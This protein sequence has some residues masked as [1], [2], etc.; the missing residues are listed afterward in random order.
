MCTLTI[1][2]KALRGYPIVALHNRYVKVGAVELTPR[3]IEASRR[4]YY[5]VDVASGGTWIG[6]NEDGLLV[7]VTNQDSHRIEEPGR[8]RGLLALDLLGMYSD[9]AEAKEHL[10]EPG[11]RGDYRWGNFVAMDGGSAWHVV[12]DRETECREIGE[13]AYAVSNLTPTAGMDRTE[14]VEELLGNAERRRSRALELAENVVGPI[15][16]AIEAMK[17]IAGDHGGEK[18]L[19]SI[20]YHDPSGRYMQSSST[21]M[22]ITDELT[23]S[24]IHYCPGNPCQEDFRDYSYVIER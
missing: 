14:R 1:L 16:A 10:M 21:L 17:G 6:V 2:Y 15:D 11:I 13:G 3:T 8:S 5:P 12:W 19:G 20:C 22:A 18:G 23:N 24:L 7:A 9:A 4:I